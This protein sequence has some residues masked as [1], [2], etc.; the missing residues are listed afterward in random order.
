[1]K[2]PNCR[3]CG[4][5]LA[6]YIYFGHPTIDPERKKQFGYGGNGVFCTLRCGYRYALNMVKRRKS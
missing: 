6:P 5:P 3:E 4:K 2:A 1:M